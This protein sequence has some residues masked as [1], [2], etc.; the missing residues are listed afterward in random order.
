M[1]QVQR[2]IACFY[3]AESCLQWSTATQILLL[4]TLHGFVHEC[5][6]S[7]SE[8]TTFGMMMKGFLLFQFLSQLV[9][10]NSM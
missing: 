10:V 7:P 2:Q 3:S 6:L 9:A 4:V 5:D 8:E 1:L